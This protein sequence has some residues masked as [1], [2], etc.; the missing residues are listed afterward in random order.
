MSTAENTANHVE[1]TTINLQPG[2]FIAAAPIRGTS[3]VLSF[4]LPFDMDDAGVLRMFRYFASFALEQ[5]EDAAD[6]AKEQAA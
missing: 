6:L 1:Q 5:E 4:D 3:S 2:H